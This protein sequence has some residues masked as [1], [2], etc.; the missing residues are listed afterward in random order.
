ML[1]LLL[2]PPDRQIPDPDPRNSSWKRYKG[3]LS[4][5]LVLSTIQVTVR[6]GSFPPHY[7]WRTPGGWSRAPTSFSLPPASREDLRLDDNL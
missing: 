5:A 4:L 6:F 1:L 2:L 7:S 3:R